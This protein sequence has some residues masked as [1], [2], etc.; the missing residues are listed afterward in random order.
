MKRLLLAI[1]LFACALPAFAQTAVA[2]VPTGTDF[3]TN[4]KTY[5]YTP[6][7]SRITLMQPYYDKNY[8]RIFVSGNDAMNWTIEFMAGR[9]ESLRPNEFFYAE[10]SQFSEGR[11]PG[12]DFYGNG[13]GCNRPSGYFDVRQIQ[14]DA[15]GVVVRLEAV[16]VAYCSWN[17]PPVAVAVQ[18]QAPALNYSVGEAD[19][20]K[21]TITYYGDTSTFSLVNT[22][23]AA[24]RYVSSG[25][26]DVWTMNFAA[27]P[28][29]AQ[30]AK[31]MYL[32]EGVA[33]PGVAGMDQALGKSR[34]TDRGKFEILTITYRN[35]AIVQLSARYWFYS[36]V[37]RTKV[38]R[39]GRINFWK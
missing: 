15:Q 11:A 32:T 37:A 12:I 17:A 10:R 1:L 23:P 16:M 7:N 14:F 25:M 39:S 19:I 31:G 26:R 35:G 9:G 20:A 28:G 18:Y 6:A 36:D 13:S 24:F 29:Q 4:G 38:I 34:R 8:V 27:P 21:P 22:T 33:A 3:V 30:F 2:I 5:T